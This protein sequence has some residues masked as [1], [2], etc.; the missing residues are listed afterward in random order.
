MKGVSTLANEIIQHDEK[1]LNGQT[2]P[3]GSWMKT[4]MI[5]NPELQKKILP[6]E[7]G[8][9]KEKPEI[10]GLSINNKLH[11]C[12]VCMEEAEKIKGN[13]FYAKDITNK[14]CM[15]P[16]FHSLVKGAANGYELDVYSYPKFLE[17]SKDMKM[18]NNN[19]EFKELLKNM[20]NAFIKQADTLDQDP[21][22]EENKE[23]L[24]ATNEPDLEKMV[25]D[26]VE[27]QLEKAEDEQPP[28]EEEPPA[29]EFDPEKEIKSL[30]EE[31][32]S[33]NDRVSKIEE[34][35]KAEQPPE[36]QKQP[37]LNKSLDK[38][39]NEVKPEEPELKKNHL[40]MPIRSS[41]ELQERR[42]NRFRL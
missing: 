12:P 36:S 23:E 34:A 1:L 35:I 18:E 20:G 5:T 2:V 38:L 7:L 17:K 3:A 25:K 33:L 6:K 26:E 24:E 29:E 30:K 40:N 9:N 27:K 41:K 10:D 15:K 19:M 32:S 39:D 13:R 28:A 4:L 11:T 37:E 31:F 42:Q 21:E 8:G 16:V 14:E 22:P